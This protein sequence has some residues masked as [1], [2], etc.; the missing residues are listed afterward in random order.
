MT[1]R[2]ILVVPPAAAAITLA[3]TPAVVPPAVRAVPPA[4]A[5]VAVPDGAGPARAR[6][7]VLTWNV[8]AGTNPRCALY[9]AGA[10]ELAWN[11]SGHAI[12]GPVTSD[13]LFLQEFCSGATA[14]LER[15]LELRTGR[16]WTVGSWS[17]QDSGGAP[18]PCH[19]DRLGRPRGTQSIAVAV[20]RHDADF[21]VHPLPAPPWYVRRAVLCATIGAIRV[22]ACNTHL[23]SG[24]RYDDRQPGAL[25]RT[26]QMRRLLDIAAEDGHRAVFGG[27]LNAAPPDSRTG[28]AA[29]RRAIAPAYRHHREC[30]QRGEARTG[31]WTHDGAAGRKKLDYVFAPPGSVRRCHVDQAVTL[32]DHRPLHAEL[33][34]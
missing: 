26:R 9:R 12:G 2:A 10:L 29:G 28:S 1:V 23:S 30:D 6:L 16:P 15:T 14:T 11:I 18:Y 31:R 25:Y 22:R 21:S 33:A 4:G 3:L 13:V 27:D 5:P 20:A 8:C 17:L 32:S 24:A 34:L 7:A 19:P